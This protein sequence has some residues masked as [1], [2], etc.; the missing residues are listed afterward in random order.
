MVKACRYVGKVGV[1][2]METVVLFTGIALTIKEENSDV[3]RG[4]KVSESGRVT[5][6]VK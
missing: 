1:P 4:R 5:V 2:E 6:A 3:E